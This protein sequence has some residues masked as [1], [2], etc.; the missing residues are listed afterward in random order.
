MN[1]I[2]DWLAG[3][4]DEDPAVFN[5]K[6]FEWTQIFRDNWAVIKNEYKEYIKASS[7]RTIPYHSEVNDVIGAC[8]A[9]SKWQTLYLRA[10]NRD[11]DIINRFPATKSLID[12]VPCTLA[13]FSILQPGAKLE[14]HRG[15][16]KGVIRYHLALSVP[17]DSENCFL[18]IYNS[19]SDLHAP[20]TTL[21]WRKGEDI[22]FDDMFLH[23]VQNNTNQQRIVLFLDIRRTFANPFVNL[24]NKL[25]L[26]FIK[27]ND[28]LDKIIERANHFSKGTTPTHR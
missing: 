4:C 17:A 18:K 21:H 15:V 1:H 20:S 13:F 9:S 8:D 5:P 24:L 7:E 19:T 11:T 28:I 26:Y 2:S 10:Y 12:K 22:M 27:S 25:L 23:E 6:D 16:Y 3:W 14:A